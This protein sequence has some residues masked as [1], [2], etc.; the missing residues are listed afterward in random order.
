MS[1]GKKLRKTLRQKLPALLP[2]VHQLS[3]KTA[4]DRYP[5]LFAGAAAAAP[6]AR[7]ILSFGCSTGEECVSLKTYFPGAEIVGADVNRLS[8]WRAGR[9]YGGNG[10]RFTYADDKALAA[11]APF[12][13]VFC[14]TVLRDTA[15]D[16]E[17]SIKD[18]YPFDRFDE[19][20]RFLDSL[21]RP[22]GL[23]VFYGNMYRFADT[24]VAKGYDTLPL[25]HIPVGKNITFA[26][27]GI[28]DGV[29]YLD[30]LFRKKAVS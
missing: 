23:L 22:G 13:V 4:L 7:R 18:R 8:L 28:N 26:R 5:D 29:Q 15:L 6:G 11:L 9:R 19:R 14:M 12:D 21:L 27:D 17:T 24:S 25:A 30:A 3:P 1:F 2:S 20:V 10:I 16:R